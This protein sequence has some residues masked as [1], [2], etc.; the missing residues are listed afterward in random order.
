MQRFWYGG[1]RSIVINATND[2]VLSD[3]LRR[4]AA[5]ILPCSAG[6]WGGFSPRG[7]HGAVRAGRAREA[8][9]SRA[10]AR[11]ACGCSRNVSWNRVISTSTS[12]GMRGC[13]SVSTAVWAKPTWPHRNTARSPASTLPPPNSALSYACTIARTMVQAGGDSAGMARTR[14]RYGERMS[15]AVNRR[16]SSTSRASRA[17]GSL[18]LTWR[19]V[20]VEARS[21]G[22]NIHSVRPG[23]TAPWL[24][25]RGSERNRCNLAVSVRAALRRRETIGVQ[26]GISPDSHTAWRRAGL[27]GDFSRMFHGV[28]RGSIGQNK[29]KSLWRPHATAQIKRN[30]SIVT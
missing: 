4:L 6:R 1:F 18:A 22:C 13:G 23:A 29:P 24:S 28:G 14:A 5:R 3:G 21:L 30:V 15:G 9:A 16:T 17:M 2:L 26:S 7:L 11:C 27:G 8:S 10:S 19:E 25:L 12:A 20:K